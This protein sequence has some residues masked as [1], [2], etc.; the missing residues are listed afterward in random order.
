MRFGKSQF[1]VLA[2]TGGVLLIILAWAFASMSDHRY[3][4]AFTFESLVERLNVISGPAGK[5]CGVI[6][7]GSDPSN[8][9]SCVRSSLAHREPFWFAS[10]INDK[11]PGGSWQGLVGDKSG[12]TWLVSYDTD[13]T[14]GA[15]ERKAYIGTNNCLDPIILSG[16]RFYVQCSRL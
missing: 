16:P 4:S 8:A 14:D 7:L 2:L 11:R 12:V 13:V 10:Q 5:K 6:T 1:A 3:S 9:L 15:G